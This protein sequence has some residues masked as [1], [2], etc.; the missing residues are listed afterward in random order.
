[1]SLFDLNG[2][3]ALV[4]GAA[5]YLG[6]ALVTALAEAGATVWLT[7][8]NAE[9]LTDFAGAMTGKGL[10]ARPL[11]FDVTDPA[12]VATALRTV[13]AESGRLD[14]LVNNAHH[15]RSGSFTTAERADFTEAAELALGAAHGLMVAA[16]PLLERA[17]ADGSPS[18]IN[19]ASMYGMV[20]PDPHAY[21][22]P[23][24]QNPPYY[25]AAKAGLLQLTRHAATHLAGNGVRVNAI[26]PGPFPS[27]APPS[28]PTLID[29][30]AAKVPLGRVGRPE[31]LAT[32]VLFLASPASTFVTGVNIPVDGGWTAW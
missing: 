8:R 31:E 29:R 7:G 3:V 15:P 19:I 9:R 20:S 24:M 28:D 11:P 16:L 27:A 22:S 4:T 2:R 30:L 21:A 23:E 1:V 12:A 13:E 14:V 17:A 32:A 18:V 26:S 10:D 25:G 6:R 5:G